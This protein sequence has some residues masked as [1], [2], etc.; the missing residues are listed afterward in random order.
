MASWTGGRGHE[1]V[2]PPTRP[3][4]DQHLMCFSKLLSPS[5]VTIATSASRL[6]HVVGGACGR[7][8]GCGRGHA[9]I[10]CNCYFEGCFYCC[11]LKG[12]ARRRLTRCFLLYIFL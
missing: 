1:Q 6:G 4:S 8:L 3:G 9:S 11:M 10:H 7:G 5:V 12:G 2:T